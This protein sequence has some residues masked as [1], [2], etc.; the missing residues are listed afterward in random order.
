[1]KKIAIVSCYFQKNYGSALQ[2]YATQRLLSEMGAVVKT[3]PIDGL[4]KEIRNRKLKYYFKHLSLNVLF[5]KLGYINVYLKKKNKFTQLS[6]NLA[7]RNDMFKKFESHFDLMPIVNGFSELSTAIRE[8]DGVVLGSDQLWLPSNLEAD[9]YTLNWVPDEIPKMSFATSFGVATLPEEYK[10]MAESFLQRIDYLSVREKDGQN[11]IK[12]VCGKEANLICD[13]TI[14]FTGEQWMSIQEEKPI[15]NEKYI[16]CYFLGD[17][18]KQREFVC[19][20]KEKTGCKIVAILHL[21][22]YVKSDEKYVDYAPY[23]V[24]PAEFLNLIRNAEYV[25]TDSFHA[26]VFSMLYHKLFFTFRRFKESYTLSTNSRLDS[27]LER[28][29]LQERIFTA[30]E[31]VEKCL[32]MEIDYDV[33]DNELDL[34]RNIAR[35]FVM[36]ILK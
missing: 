25:C 29:G 6:K 5:G 27:L 26:T 3:V 9:F 16:F 15:I 12:D 1:M 10:S 31:N 23:D 13:P 19:R 35:D 20:L 34:L 24:G 2:A 33:I 32:S 18:P 30:E 4:K 36:Q 28:V 17:N 7:A 21:N 14:M 8:Y 22:V 11:I